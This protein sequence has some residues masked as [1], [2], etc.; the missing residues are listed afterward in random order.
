MMYNDYYIYKDVRP[1]GEYIKIQVIRELRTVLS[2]GLKE[3]KNIADFMDKKM[4]GGSSG[5]TYR[6]N[7]T[8]GQALQLVR[9]GFDVWHHL[10]GKV[11]EENNHLPDELF[12]I[13]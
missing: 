10:G 11:R 9:L 6:L 13:E 8:S 1:N 12:V 2:I 3:A 5:H 7:M 4:S